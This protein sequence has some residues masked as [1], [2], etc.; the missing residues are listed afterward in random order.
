MNIR[1]NPSN[2][3]LSAQQ[4]AE[5]FSVSTDTIYRWRRDGRFPAPVRLSPGTTRWR[6][7]DIIEFEESLEACFA[8][9][10]IM[11]F[12]MAAAA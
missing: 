1:M 7:S 11:Y 4:V 2:S 12:D 6:L 10:A 5:R 9:R 8:V 3:Y